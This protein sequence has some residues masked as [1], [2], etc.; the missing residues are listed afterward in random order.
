LNT[1]YLTIDLEEI[2]VIEINKRTAKFTELKPYDFTAKAND[3]ME[4]CEWTNGE[5]VDVTIESN[6]HQQF[7]LTW[8]Q[9]EALQAL[10]AYK[11]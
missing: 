1:V 9:W 7:S 3:F 2:T 10:I 5:G 11:E 4:I 8:T 6:G